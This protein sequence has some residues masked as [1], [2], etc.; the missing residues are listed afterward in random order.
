MSV[1]RSGSVQVVQ[2]SGAVVGLGLLVLVV[3]SLVAS[4][5]SRDSSLPESLMADP[6]FIVFLDSPRLVVDYSRFV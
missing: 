1:T 4:A 6:L 2:C 5:G 3:S